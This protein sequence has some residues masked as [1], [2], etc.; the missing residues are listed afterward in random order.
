MN[1]DGQLL[2][3]EQGGHCISIFND[4]GRN[5]KSFSSRPGQLEWPYGITISTTADILVCDKGNNRIN[6]FSP[7]G[8]S[9]QCIGTKGNGPLQ[10]NA[11][12]G[13]AVHPHS[14][15]I[16]VTITEFRSSMKT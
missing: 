9:L 6:I 4:N 2:V 13:I 7:D 11:P 1:N 8:K 14:N 12:H 16:Y 5:K 10:F 3:A 15:K